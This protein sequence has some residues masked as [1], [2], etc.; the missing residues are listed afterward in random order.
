[1]AKPIFVLWITSKESEASYKAMCEK[2]ESQLKNE[3]HVLIFGNMPCVKTI[4]LSEY[5]K[6]DDNIPESRPLRTVG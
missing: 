2:I 5:N 1:M 4:I 3:Y 6:I